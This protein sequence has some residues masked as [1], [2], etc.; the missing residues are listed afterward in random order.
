MNKTVT[1]PNCS[2][3]TWSTIEVVSLRRTSELHSGSLTGREIYGDIT[4]T[5]EVESWKCAHCGESASDAL[6]ERLDQLQSEI[7]DWDVSGF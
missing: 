4:S 3:D 6:C 1:C 7:E 2:H 5:T